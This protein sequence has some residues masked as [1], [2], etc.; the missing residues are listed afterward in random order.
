MKRTGTQPL[1]S[2]AA[3]EK[4]DQPPCGGNQFDSVGGVR[5]LLAEAKK[6][7]RL[8]RC[9]WKAG[10]SIMCADVLQTGIKRL[11]AAQAIAMRRVEQ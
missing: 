9:R 4:F 2:K 8:A 11:Q 7:I 3:G 10:D 6:A 5:P 1:L